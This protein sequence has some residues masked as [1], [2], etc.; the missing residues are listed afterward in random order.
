M[1]Y[2]SSNRSQ[3]RGCI[4]I[5]AL[6]PYRNLPF[7]VDSFSGSP[8]LL[9]LPSAPESFG[10]SKKHTPISQVC[11]G[12]AIRILLFGFSRGAYTVRVGHSFI[13]WLG[14]EPRE[15]SV[16]RGSKEFA[17]QSRWTRVGGSSDKPN[18]ASWSTGLDRTLVS[19]CALRKVGG[20]YDSLV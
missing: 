15:I 18:E 5:L 17:T 9:G 16:H 2:G 4:M 13:R 20:G 14:V 3:N 6:A 12:L 19:R 11:G 1:L 10:R 8:R 7:A